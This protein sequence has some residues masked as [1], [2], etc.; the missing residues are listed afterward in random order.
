MIANKIDLLPHPGPTVCAIK[1]RTDL[2]VLPAS[3]LD[4]RGVPGLTRALTALWA[5]QAVEAGRPAAEP[6]CAASAA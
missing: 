6:A 1:A 3:A 5:G 4:G 2:P